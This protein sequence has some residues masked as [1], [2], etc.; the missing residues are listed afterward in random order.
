M[1]YSFL[2]TAAYELLLD[3][4][5]KK[6]DA[7]R[8]QGIVHLFIQ[9]VKYNKGSGHFLSHFKP[10]QGWYDSATRGICG[11][12][13]HTGTCES[14]CPQND[15]S[16]HPSTCVALSSDPLRKP[17]YQRHPGLIIIGYLLTMW[18]CIVSIIMSIIL[19]SMI[20]TRPTCPSYS[21]IHQPLASTPHVKVGAPKI[22]VSCFALPLKN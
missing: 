1:Y 19:M 8:S 15:S 9:P 4:P 2:K 14:N 13:E 20:S 21:C 3:F 16:N 12:F 6:Y 5:L 10:S 11:H 22:L 17:H 18:A 7:H